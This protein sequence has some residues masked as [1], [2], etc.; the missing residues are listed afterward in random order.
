VVPPVS[1]PAGTS[2]EAT[3]HSGV[4]AAELGS[5]ANGGESRSASWASSFPAV[6]GNAP[7]VGL[8]DATAFHLASLA[9]G[10]IPPEVEFWL[11]QEHAQFHQITPS[12]V[13]DAPSWSDAAGMLPHRF[14]SFMAHAKLVP[15]PFKQRVLQVENVLRQRLSQEQAEMVL[16]GG[17]A[18]PAAYYFMLNV[19][20]QNLLR[21]A[22]T[23]C[24]AQ[25]QFT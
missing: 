15:I 17:R 4:A 9:E 5:T 1:D 24:T 8:L 21:D 20:R 3:R 16:G 6:R 23:Q 14:C 13:V 11:F 18:D 12:E 25:A 10:F 19:S 22:F 2:L 7:S